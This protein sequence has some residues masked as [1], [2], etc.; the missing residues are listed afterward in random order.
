MLP[1]VVRQWTED[2]TKKMVKTNA[3]KI[4]LAINIF[5][6]F[7]LILLFMIFSF[8]S[9]IKCPYNTNTR[10]RYILWSKMKMDRNLQIYFLKILFKLRIER[11]IYHLY[12]LIILYLIREI[13][14]KKIIQPCNFTLK[15]HQIVDILWNIIYQNVSK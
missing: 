15:A 5:I 8:L 13:K 11:I 1:D 7:F 14:K 10:T 12:I 9:V 2:V 4:F 6:R 3:T